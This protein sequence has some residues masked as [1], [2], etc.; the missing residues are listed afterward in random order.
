MPQTGCLGA[1]QVRWIRMLVH[2]LLLRRNW[3]VQDEKCTAP[4][5]AGDAY[6]AAHRFHHAL[7]QMQAEANATDL[8]VTNGLH[9]VKWLEN[10]WQLV[11]R[12]P[13][14]FVLN[15]DLNFAS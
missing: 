15:A 10:M 5:L 1:G 2:P 13:D 6:T 7:H 11:R 4:K 14:A 12:N 9:T 3:E 8:G